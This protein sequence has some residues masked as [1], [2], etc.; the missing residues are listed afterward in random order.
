[1]VRGSCLCGGVRFEADAIQMISTCHC[2]MCR[3]AHGAAYGVFA[4]AF[5]D[6]FRFTA[7]DIPEVTLKS[8]PDPNELREM[9][10]RYA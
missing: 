9:L 10:G 8:M 7:G 4:N 2:S 3:K 1:M 6:D 5:W